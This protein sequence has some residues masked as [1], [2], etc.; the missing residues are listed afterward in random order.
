MVVFL[1]DPFN[2]I[3]KEILQWTDDFFML[4]CFMREIIN[5]PLFV[6]IYVRFEDIW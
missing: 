1:Y 2:V 4:L 6:G 5:N 3:L